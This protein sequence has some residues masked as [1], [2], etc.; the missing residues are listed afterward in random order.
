MDS[1]ALGGFAAFSGAGAVALA[2][3]NSGIATGFDAPRWQVL[4][5]T[6]RCPLK[7]SLLIAIVIVIIS[8]A[9]AF[10]CF[11]SLS[12]GFTWQNAHST[13]SDAEIK[14]IEGIS[15]SAGISFNT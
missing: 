6:S 8:R 4:Q 10:S 1:V 11:S 2:S 14:F 12:N 3:M 7:L 15:E 5:V 9:V 13:P